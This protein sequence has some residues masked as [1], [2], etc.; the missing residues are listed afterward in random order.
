LV[1]EFIETGGQEKAKILLGHL[2]G[3]KIGG[4]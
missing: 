3:K 2:Q 1:K 4:V